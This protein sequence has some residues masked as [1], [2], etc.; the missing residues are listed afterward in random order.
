VREKVVVKAPTR[1]PALD[2][3]GSEWSRERLDGDDVAAVSSPR[4]KGVRRVRTVVRVW[5]GLKEVAAPM[6][7]SD[8]KILCKTYACMERD[9][10]NTTTYIM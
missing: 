6:Y 8:A 4:M 2:L 3:K 5:N 10:N 1:R 7:L 9:N